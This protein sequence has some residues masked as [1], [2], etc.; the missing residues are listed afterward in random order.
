MTIS[1]IDVESTILRTR[2]ELGKSPDISPGLRSAIEI[3]LLL[4]SILFQR[5]GLNTKNSSKPS[6][7]DPFRK[8]LSLRKRSG[9]KPGAQKG[10]MGNTLLKV[11]EPDEVVTHRVRQ[12]VECGRDLS[13]QPNEGG[14]EF[15]QVFEVEFNVRVTEHQSEKKTCSCGCQ[16]MGQ[17]PS[18][19]EKAVQYGPGVKAF[20]VYLSQYQLIPYKRIE[21]MFAD[22][23][24]L[25]LS[26]GSIVNFNEEAA[27][28]LVSFE[29]R[30][31]AELS[32]SALLNAD[33]TGVRIEKQTMWLHSA[34]ND[35]WTLLFPHPK[36]GSE[37]MQDIG[38]LPSYQ[39]I[40]IHD[41]WKAYFKLD[42]LRHALCNAHHLRELEQVIQFDHQTWASQMKDLLLEIL[43]EKQLKGSVESE[44]QLA[45]QKRYR[46]ILSKGEAECPFD[47]KPKGQPGRTKKSKARNLL[48]RLRDFEE[49]TL[50]FMREPNVP[51]TN[52]QSEQD[53]R[54]FKV[55]QK[56]SG[57]FRSIDA[58]KDFC[59]IRSFCSTVRKHDNSVYDAITRLMRDN[60]WKLAE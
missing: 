42:G 50:R 41:H 27:H 32:K 56:I 20:A 39:G 21:E 4:V 33:E 26:A 29:E 10:H 9:K 17:F 18:G 36:R 8:P 12:C 6:S 24:G 16:N 7:T 48:E 2:E 25:P 34:S 52:N 49:E 45:F 58:A 30:A 43:H 1:G 37:A 55:Q 51:F 53:I 13:N 3:L 57:S 19:V 22:Q 35:R 31:R 60:D 23:F 38:L 11:P 46:T 28:R 15:R 40:L 59:R 5:L 54:M 14:I 47:K 44:K